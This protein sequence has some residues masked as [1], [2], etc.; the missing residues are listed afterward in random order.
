MKK[1]LIIAF[2]TLFGI[3]C[4]AIYNYTANDFATCSGGNNC[5]ACKNCKY[6]KNCAKNGG[7]C[8]VCK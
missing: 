3:S 6:C 2:F 7:S 8:S 4:F 1:Y 5:N